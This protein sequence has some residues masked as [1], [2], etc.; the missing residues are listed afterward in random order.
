M[1][2]GDGRS[3][4]SAEQ[5]DLSIALVGDVMLNRRISLHDEPGFLKLRTI[6]Q[7]ADAA[8]ANLETTVRNDD[9]G[10]PTLSYA[11]Y[12]TMPPAMLDEQIGRAHV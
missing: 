5:G 8:F 12:T 1:A 4:Y 9:E 7:D 3:L 11:T 6:L 10:T 2:T